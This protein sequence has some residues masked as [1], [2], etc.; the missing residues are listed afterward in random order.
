MVAH[1]GSKQYNGG[2]LRAPK[3]CPGLQCDQHLAGFAALCIATFAALT[4]ELL[5]Y[6]IHDRPHPP[7]P[8][9]LSIRAQKGVATRRAR[10]GTA[11]TYATRLANHGPA[12]IREQQLHILQGCSG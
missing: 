11:S 12:R 6:P 7:S 1:P 9:E 5:V 3:S 2:V 10:Y 8:E 4:S